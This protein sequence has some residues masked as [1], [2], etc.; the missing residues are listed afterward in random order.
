VITAVDTSVLVAI[1][2]AEPDAEAWLD[3]LAEA[4]MAGALVICE[5]VAA[6]FFAVVMDRAAFHATLDDLGIQVVS[7]S[8]EAACL[9]GA[10]FREYRDAGG[11]RENLI[12]DFL[13][14]A[15]AQVD[16]GA[17][18]ASDRGYL[19]RYFEKLRLVRPA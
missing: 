1:D 8:V 11:P 5:V 4:R 13:I 19:R 16:C 17:L 12:P 10:T 18:A 3:C 2:Q 15:Q 9:A 7:S 14:A 6:E